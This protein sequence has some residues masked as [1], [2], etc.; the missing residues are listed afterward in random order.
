MG[1]PSKTRPF[2]PTFKADKPFL[3]A[4]CD[5]ETNSILFLG[6]LLSPQAH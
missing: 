2:I 1:N 5:A 4:I 6:R 3:F